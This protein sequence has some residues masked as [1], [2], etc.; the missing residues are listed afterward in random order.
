[1]RR[2]THFLINGIMLTGV[3]LIFQ[4]AESIFT[5]YISAKIGESG[6]G[7]F[8][9]VMSIYRFGVTLSLSGINLAAT[10]RIAERL[11]EKN[12]SRLKSV[13]SRC[14]SLSLIFGTTIAAG[15]FILSP[16]L[17]K[18]VLK[19]EDTII[20]LHILSLSLPFLAASSAIS[21]YFTAVRAP[22]KSTISSVF[23]F[24]I[25]ILSTIF[26]LSVLP[27]GV[28]SSCLSLSLGTTLSEIA[29]FIVIFI[30]FL[31][32]RR[33]YCSEITKGESTT[34]EILSVSLPVALSSYV[35]SALYTLEQLFIP[36][37]LMKYGLSRTDAL[38]NY[39]M[40]KGM[41]LPV[42]ITPSALMYSFSG[43]LVPELAEAKK[44]NDNKKTE[45]ITSY[46]FYLSFLY[47]VAVCGVIFFYADELSLSLFKNT[48]PAF[49]LK[50][51]APLT[52]VMYLDGAVD[53]ILKGLGEQV[54]CMRV[55]ILDA[56]LSLVLVLIL[57]PKMGI[58]GYAFVILISEIFNT[59][60]SVLKLLKI[61]SLK[62]NFSRSLLMPIFFIISACCFSKL[63]SLIFPTLNF[64]VAAGFAVIIYI[65]LS[66]C[67]SVFKW[68]KGVI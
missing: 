50:S 53:N 63:L 60:L 31:F 34:K 29:G 27:F 17:G 64:F 55:N 28:K 12:Y 49:Y 35:R 54:Y 19:S 62:I 42:L 7:L 36:S 16:F 11:A 56:A 25:R 37:S 10:R 13:S 65:L 20:S 1:M 44:L 3:S 5:V 57:V 67:F 22:A 48:T 6:V 58:A 41:V 66:V 68:K 8:G 38:G 39:G 2:I 23:S 46:V 9:L 59:F 26:F 51:L 18:T 30:L 47:S 40:I 61:T 52:I 4:L 15:L 24:I 45:K 21:G 14:I 43:L 32:D 33:K